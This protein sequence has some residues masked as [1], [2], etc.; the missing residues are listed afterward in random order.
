MTDKIGMILGC[1]EELRMT[2][3][4][5]KICKPIAEA[6]EWLDVSC[7]G[8]EYD[9][10]VIGHHPKTKRLGYIPAY[11]TNPAETMRMLVALADWGVVRVFKIDGRDL[12]VCAVSVRDNNTFLISRAEFEGPNLEHAIAEA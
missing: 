8:G 10:C 5:A 4:K 11:L 3:E 2:L 9:I 7:H 1:P 12:Y 6:E